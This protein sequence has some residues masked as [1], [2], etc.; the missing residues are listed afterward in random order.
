MRFAKLSGAGNDFVLVES[1]GRAAP[2][3]AR[4]LCD[5]REGVGADGVLFLRRGRPG[6]AHR[7]HYLNADGS[8]A[9]CG[10][11]TRCAAWWLSRTG[12]GRRLRP[13]TDA[14]LLEAVVEGEGRVR[15]RMPRAR[16]L[17]LGLELSA[18]GRRWIVHAID[19]GVPHAVVAVQGLSRFPVERFA[20][21]LRRHRAWGRA[22]ANVDFIERRGEG[23]FALRTFERGVEGETLACGT[24]A[25]AAAVVLE[26]LGLAHLPL[27]LLTRGGTLTVRRE[28]GALWLEGPARIVFTGE[29]RL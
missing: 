1:G 19:T 9:F 12:G 8:R 14:G 3:V 17:R 21:P 4:R 13:E 22:G 15:V 29:V 25:L 16:G 23:V 11:G 7:L 20:P 18:A 6:G 10:N 5:R 27:G 2:A 28:R 24:G 26:T